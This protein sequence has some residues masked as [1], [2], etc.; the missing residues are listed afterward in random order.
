MQVEEKF[1]VLKNQV[2]KKMTN[3]PVG[4][5][6]IQIKNGARAGK[7]EMSISYTKLI[8][9]VS[10]VLEKMGIIEKVTVTDGKVNFMISYAY[11]QPVLMD[12]KLIS[13]PGRRIYKNVAELSAHKGISRYVISTPKGVMG[14]GDALK[15]G[16]GG[17]VIAEIW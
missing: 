5:Y 8:V 13:K 10:K 4:D 2:G 6:L 9:E 14:S 15:N 16:V 12:V 17:E 11:K 3:Y 7:K 1:Q